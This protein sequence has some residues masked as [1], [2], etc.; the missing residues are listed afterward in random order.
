[1]T[2]QSNNQSDSDERLFAGAVYDELSNIAG[3]QVVHPPRGFYRMHLFR[4]AICYIVWFMVVF[5]LYTLCN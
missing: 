3:A 5:R 2:G 1:M 4:A